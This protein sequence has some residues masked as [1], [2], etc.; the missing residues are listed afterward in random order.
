[1][2]PP[3]AAL[4]TLSTLTSPARPLVAHST[5]ISTTCI[6]VDKTVHIFSFFFFNAADILPRH[7][8]RRTFQP[9]PGSRLITSAFALSLHSRACHN[10]NLSPPP[11][12]HPHPKVHLIPQFCRHPIRN[13]TLTQNPKS[14]NDMMI[15][16]SS[17]HNSK[18][19]KFH[20]LS[21][22]QLLT[23]SVVTEQH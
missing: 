10:L 15:L 20:S 17:Y 11:S 21:D 16:I 23:V 5:L 18:K 1:M 12:P 14:I 19:N 2:P 8:T 6:P 7:V 22:Y 9:P 13:L 4:N 3:L